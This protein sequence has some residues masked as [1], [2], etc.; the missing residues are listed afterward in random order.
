MWQTTSSKQLTEDAQELHDTWRKKNPRL[1]LTLMDD[2]EAA[3]FI[4]E[5]YGAEVAKV[6]ELYPVAVMRADF[7]RLAILYARGGIYGDIDTRCLKPIVK[8][9]PPRKPRPSDPVFVSNTSWTA[10]GPLQYHNLT[11][12]DCSLVAAVE[13]NVHMC[14]WLIAAAPGHPIVRAALSIAL[15]SVEDGFDCGY[16]HMVHEHTG[17]AVWT[18]AFGDVL[19][20]GQD[21]TAAQ[22]SKAAWTDPAVYKRARALKV[23]V[24]AYTFFG[25][26]WAGKANTT[27]QNAEN[28]Y[29]STWEDGP[30]KS[31]L[32]ERE[33][34]TAAVKRWGRGRQGGAAGSRRLWRALL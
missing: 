14:N 18:R 29:S 31:W 15:R 21:A 1:N 8:W 13:N 22:I 11:W 23:C 9:M 7:W 24:V 3:A 26:R 12:D 34:V 20:L 2:G 30:N 17:P 32:K 19:G 25:S 10:P 4:Q 27:A 6:Y 5:F 16:E 33:K 28:L